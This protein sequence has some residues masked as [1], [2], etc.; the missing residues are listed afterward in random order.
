VEINKL[1]D[2]IKAIDES[3]EKSIRNLD[4]VN[5]DDLINEFK[6]LESHVNQKKLE[7]DQRASKEATN[8]V[9]N[10][11]SSLSERIFSK[12]TF[13]LK[14]IPTK[15]V[16]F[17]KL[18]AP[19]TIPRVT[20]DRNQVNQNTKEE[21]AREVETFMSLN[22]YNRVAAP[23]GAKDVTKEFIEWRTNLKS[24]HW[25]TLQKSSAQN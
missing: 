23:E 1:Q 2:E 12:Y 14:E 21:L 6:L 18:S 16:K 11:S 13:Q 3:Y 5:S 22:H 9:R 10:F 20:F 19:P 15:T 17:P 8:L 4:L 24:G 7:I 25:E